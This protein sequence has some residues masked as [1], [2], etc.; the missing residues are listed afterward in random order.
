L[1]RILIIEDNENNRYLARF[2]LEHAGFEVQTAVDGVQGLSLARGGGF[3]LIVLDVEM[4]RMDGYETAA[5]LLREPASARVP[6]VG[7][8]SFA[9]SGDR[10][11]AMR[12][13]FAGYIEKPIDPATFAEQIRGFLEGR[14]GG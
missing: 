6:I 1:K 4:P 10:D 5:A 11:R 7:V 13:G 2:L 8:S 3:A 12:A 9:M 14:R